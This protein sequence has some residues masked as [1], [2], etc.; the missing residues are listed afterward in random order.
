MYVDIVISNAFN[1]NKHFFLFLFFSLLFLLMR[2]QHSRLHSNAPPTQSTSLECPSN[3]AY[4]TLFA[5]PTQPTSLEF[6]SNTAYF[7]LMPLEHSLLHSICA[8][9]TAHFTLM[10]LQHSLLQGT[11]M[12]HSQEHQGNIASEVDPKNITFPFFSLR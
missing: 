1:L 7:I 4:F 5:P 9:N 2:L 10:R 8:C 3:T 12:E 11:S 6:A